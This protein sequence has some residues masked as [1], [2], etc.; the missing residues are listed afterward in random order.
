MTDEL[1]VFSIVAMATVTA[2]LIAATISFVNLT[3]TKELKTSEF[4]Q[5]WINDL[6]DE[7]SVFFACAR[8]FSR[9]TEE[10]Y[11]F[12]ESSSEENVF[13]ISTD[14]ISE[15]RYQVGEAYSKIILQLNYKEQ[16][17]EELVRMMKI[18][19]SKQN[20]ALSKKSDSTETIKA[21]SIA[22]D[23][24]RTLIKKEWDRVKAGEPA[25]RNARNAA[26]AG[27]ITLCLAIIVFIVYGAFK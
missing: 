11:Y 12:G 16:D 8:A 10:Q 7:L 1:P 18:V 4:R 22:T 24:S 15:I 17:H 26:I 9:A 3:L 2:S 25:Y 13:K 21:I 27:I 5:E 6:R 23:Y 14:K 20:E 19:I